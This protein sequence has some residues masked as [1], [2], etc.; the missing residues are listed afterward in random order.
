[1]METKQEI[2]ERLAR[3]LKIN[4]D[5]VLKM[6]KQEQRRIVFQLQDE[7]KR[8]NKNLFVGTSTIKR[9]LRLWA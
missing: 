6:T 4:I 1:M 3:E 2:V 9:A 5:E 7:L 8:R